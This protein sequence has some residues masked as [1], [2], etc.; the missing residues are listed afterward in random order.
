MLADEGLDGAGLPPRTLCLTYDD[1]PGPHTAELGRFLFEQGIEA[2]FFVIG[3]LAAGALPVLRQLRAWGHVVANHTW[4]H[5]GL[6]DLALAGGDVVEEI[7]RADAVIRPYAAGPVLLRPP[8]G[9]WRESSRPNGPQDAP[10]SIVA[11]RLL[12]QRAVRRLRR[13]D[14]LGHRRRGLGVL[15]EIP[16]G[17]RVREATRRRDRSPGRRHRAHAR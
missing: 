2:A 10:T 4:S 16:A 14:P 6:V 17:L 15:A 12:R 13:P 5:P 11:Q 1:G 3:Q 7:A 9:S 8:Y